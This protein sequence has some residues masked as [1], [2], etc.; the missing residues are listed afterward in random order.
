M[1][2]VVLGRENGLGD[3]QDL[4]TG[5]RLKKCKHT[6]PCNRQNIKVDTLRSNKEIKVEKERMENRIKKRKR[7]EIRK[8]AG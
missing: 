3:V 2:A 1:A 7:E 6:M 8:V 4:Q 5:F